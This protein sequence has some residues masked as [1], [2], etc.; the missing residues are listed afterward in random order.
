MILFGL[1][2]INIKLILTTG[3]MEELSERQKD[4]NLILKTF[5]IKQMR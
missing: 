3:T 4:I 2:C 5:E 1:D